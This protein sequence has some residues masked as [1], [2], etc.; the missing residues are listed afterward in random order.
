MSDKPPKIKLEK[1]SKTFSGLTALENISLEIATGEFVAVVGHSG[2]GKS[3]LLRLINKLEIPSAGKILVDNTDVALIKGKSLRELRTR[4]GY[5]FQNFGLVTSASAQ[6]NVLMGAL[7]IL[8]FPRIGV[9]TYPK[10]LRNR[11]SQLLASVGLS[12]YAG[13]KI[14]EL[15]GGQMQRVSVAR[16]MML[17]PQLILADEPISSLDPVMAEETMQILKK[18]NEGGTTVLVSLHQVD[19]ALKYADRIVGLQ[20]GRILLD[21]PTNKIPKAE[22]VKIYT[23]LDE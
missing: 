15:S 2:S 3:T 22:L 17:D 5:I 7:G 19:I 4:I 20:N 18:A 21:K 14:N 11:S 10:I 23:A 16:A 13:K 9:T 1:V 8:K 6:E 12:E